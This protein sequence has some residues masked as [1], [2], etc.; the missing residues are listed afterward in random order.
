MNGINSSTQFFHFRLNNY[1]IFIFKYGTIFIFI[2]YDSC[3]IF[4]ISRKYN[5]LI[6]EKLLST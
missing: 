1:H 5:C 3:I 4:K 6:L 2:N